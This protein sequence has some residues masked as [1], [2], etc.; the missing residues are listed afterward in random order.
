MGT[1]FL[2]LAAGS[3]GAFMLVIGYLSIEDAVTSHKK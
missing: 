1:L 2:Y 3:I